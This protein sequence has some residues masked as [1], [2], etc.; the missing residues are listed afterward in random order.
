MKGKIYIVCL[1]TIKFEKD[2]NKHAHWVG[3]QKLRSLDIYDLSKRTPKFDKK[4]A[5]VIGNTE[6]EKN[7]AKNT[8][9]NAHKN[10]GNHTRINKNK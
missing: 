1:P 6:E 3:N 2:N 8:T 5:S 10:A 4:D 7:S 9:Y